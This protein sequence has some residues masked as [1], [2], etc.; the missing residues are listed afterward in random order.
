LNPGLLDS[1]ALVAWLTCSCKDFLKAYEKKEE[2]KKEMFLVYF[3]ESFLRKSAM[4]QRINLLERREAERAMRSL[5]WKWFIDFGFRVE[6]CVPL[7]ESGL[8]E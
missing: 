5:P 7:A 4:Q 8:S 6:Q 3:L 2:K 1:K